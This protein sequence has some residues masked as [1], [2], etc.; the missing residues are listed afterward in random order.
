MT[1]LLWFSYKSD[2]TPLWHHASLTPRQCDTTPLS[3]HASLTPRHCDTMPLWHH[4]SVTPRH[5]DTTPVWHHASV[6]P[7]HCDTTPVWHHAIVTPRCLLSADVNGI[8]CAVMT[9][10]ID[11]LIVCL[12]TLADSWTDEFTQLEHEADFWEKLQK[13]WDDLNGFVPYFFYCTGCGKKSSP[14]TFFAV[15]SATAWNLNA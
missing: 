14:L 4:A 10:L 8:I 3:H 1:G 13:Q 6:T 11:Y 7:R 2:T 5:C 12:K 9:C 15:F